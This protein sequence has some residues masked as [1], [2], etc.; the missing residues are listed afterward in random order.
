MTPD[1]G[2]ESLLIHSPVPETNSGPTNPETN[3][4]GLNLNL[5][6]DNSPRGFNRSRDENLCLVR[7]WSKDEKRRKNENRRNVRKNLSV[8]GW[9]S[10]SEFD[11]SI[12]SSLSEDSSLSDPER[13]ESKDNCSGSKNRGRSSAASIRSS[14][15]SVRSSA[16]SQLWEKVNYFL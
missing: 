3:L 16:E 14:V 7:S 8:E 12:S 13:F 15:G 11:G 1:K 4:E 10:G 2:Y 9:S 5:L 6:D